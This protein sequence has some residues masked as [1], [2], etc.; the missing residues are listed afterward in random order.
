[1]TH[2]P[3]SCRALAIAPGALCM[4]CARRG[5]NPRLPARLDPFTN[6]RRS[7]ARRPPSWRQD[8]WRS[9]HCVAQGTLPH[10]TS[11]K[12]EGRSPSTERSA[13]R[14]RSGRQ[15]RI[16]SSG[17]EGSGF[18]TDID[19]VVM[20]VRNPGSDEAWRRKTVCRR[21]AHAALATRA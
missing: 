4:T 12:E 6:A 17:E 16:S 10:K 18:R 1:M 11:A 2:G 5:V 8:R 19:L 15:I 21:S 9:A 20:S 14:E 3:T 7:A 13:R